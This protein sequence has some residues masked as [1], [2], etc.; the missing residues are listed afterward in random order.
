MAKMV[1]ERV[2]GLTTL[3]YFISGHRNITDEEFAEHY[4]PKIDQGIKEG[5]IFVVGD[6]YGADQKAQDYLKKK[7]YDEMKVRVHHMLKKPRYCVW[8]FKL[9]G[10]RSDEERDSAMTLAST[11]DIAWVRP[12]KGDSGTAQNIARRVRDEL[13]C[14]IAE[15]YHKINKEFGDKNKFFDLFYDMMHDLNKR[16]GEATN[17]YVEENEGEA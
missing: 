13:M 15:K 12:G 2:R 10:F 6:Y 16:W 14:D 17:E 3:V 5:A 11:H 7:S 4:I 8:S 9:G 1:T